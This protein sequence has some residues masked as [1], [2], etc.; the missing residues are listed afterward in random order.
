MDTRQQ[1]AERIL[2]RG[3][4]FRLPAPFF[5]RLLRL[6]RIT[7][8]PLYPGTILEFAIIVLENKLEEALEKSDYE[9]LVMSIKPIARCVAVSILNDEQKI[10][11]ETDKLQQWLLWK[12]HPEL[13]IQMFRTVAKLNRTSDFLNITRYYVVQTSMM[14]NPNLGQE[15]NGR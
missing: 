14:M 12:V 11:R 1:A 9:M 6:N 4:R 10:E 5:S 7:V 8:C 3:V 13:L 15:E 2:N